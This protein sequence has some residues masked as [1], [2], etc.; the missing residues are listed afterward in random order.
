MGAATD[1][2]GPAIRPG[3]S[4]DA[5]TAVTGHPGE[6]LKMTVEGSGGSLPTGDPGHIGGSARKIK[7]GLQVYGAQNRQAL[8]SWFAKADEV[9]EEAERVLCS[10]SPSTAESI[11]ATWGPASERRARSMSAHPS[12]DGAREGRVAVVG[13]RSGDLILPPR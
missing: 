12:R 10:F 9:L 2:H 3:A 4:R 13:A 8:E 5:K 11:K 1:G 7:E 6:P